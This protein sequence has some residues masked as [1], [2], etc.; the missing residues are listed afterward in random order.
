M[1]EV[2]VNTFLKHYC[3]LWLYAIYF[4]AFGYLPNAMFNNHI[5]G[6]VNKLVS[7]S[8]AYI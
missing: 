4:H 1:D 6:R 5:P 2:C 7:V 8:F 3:V